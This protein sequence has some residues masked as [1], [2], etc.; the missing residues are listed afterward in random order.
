M[1]FA[2]HVFGGWL[3]AASVLIVV[4]CADPCEDLQELCDSCADP[5]QRASCERSVDEDP[6]EVCEQNIDSFR[7]VC[8]Q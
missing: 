3:A 2:P 6:S 7:R 4:G 1:R 8:Q 5:N